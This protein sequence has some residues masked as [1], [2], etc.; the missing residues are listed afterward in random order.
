[1][2]FVLSKKFRR[3]KFLSSR[4]SD[5]NYFL[6]PLSGKRAKKKFSSIAKFNSD[7]LIVFSKDGHFQPVVFAI[8]NRGN[9][10]SGLVF[11]S[12][13][14]RNKNTSLSNSDLIY[15]LNS[16]NIFYNQNGSL[17]GWG[18]KYGGGLVANFHN[19][20]QLSINNFLGMLSFPDPNIFSV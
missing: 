18:Q 12:I 7:D 11:T 1:M 16:G 20:P 14:R 15:D 10:V 3:N 13:K 17:R 4:T 19:Q 2:G 5:I 8:N 9:H 6:V